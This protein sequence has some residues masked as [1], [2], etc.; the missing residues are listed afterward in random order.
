MTRPVAFG[1]QHGHLDPSR[2]ESSPILNVIAD[3]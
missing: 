3:E 2:H 1:A